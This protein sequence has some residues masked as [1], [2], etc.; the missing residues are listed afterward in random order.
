MPSHTDI[1]HENLSG[2]PLRYSLGD[3]SCI[4]ALTRLGLAP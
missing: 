1:Q 3:P 4:A 2:V